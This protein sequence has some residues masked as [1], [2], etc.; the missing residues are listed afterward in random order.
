[1]GAVTWPCSR[2]PA[3]RSGPRPRRETY[4]YANGVPVRANIVAISRRHARSVA[5]V[6][7]LT[8]TLTLHALV[9]HYLVSETK[10]TISL[11]VAPSVD[12]VWFEA[13]ADFLPIT[14]PRF[15][16]PLPPAPAKP[17]DDPPPKPAPD[18]ARLPLPIQAPTA[19]ENSMVAAPVPTPTESAPTF[20]DQLEAQRS[21][22]A[23]EMAQESARK[24]RPF[25]GRSIDAM[26]PGADVGRLPGFRPRVDGGNR[27]TL[28]RLAKIL[29]GALP[30]AAVNPDAPTDLLTE[31][32]E[33][34]HHSSDLAAC[35]LQYEQFESDLRRQ[36]CGEVR[37][38]Q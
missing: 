9:I 34:A 19:V 20:S 6:G 17:L 11:A 25:A 5:R 28:R 16:E 2:P 15:A 10:P 18:L 8:G 4:H 30:S 7:A 22:V 14:P 27:E 26:L 32:W 21:T 1:V 23:A 13:P 24:R 37:P 31:G 3:R 36:L 35:E 38:P 29:G 33:R 12:L